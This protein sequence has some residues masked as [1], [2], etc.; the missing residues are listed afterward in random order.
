M[1]YKITEIFNE[2]NDIAGYAGSIGFQASREWRF[3]PVAVETLASAGTGLV[4]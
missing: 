2:A 3:M 1:R 4:I